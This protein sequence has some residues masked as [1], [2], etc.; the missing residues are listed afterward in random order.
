MTFQKNNDLESNLLF[1]ASYAQ[2]HVAPNL[3]TL[4]R[5][6]WAISPA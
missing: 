5:A 6:R 2:S 3:T 1:A 4:G